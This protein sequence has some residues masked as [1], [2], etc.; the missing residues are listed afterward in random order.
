[1]FIQGGG[2]RCNSPICVCYRSVA[3][4]RFGF[5]LP[6]AIFSP[7]LAL[8]SHPPPSSNPNFCDVQVHKAEKLARERLKE[9]ETPSML[10]ALG[11]LTQDPECWERARE[12]S[13]RRYAH[14]KAGSGNEMMVVKCDAYDLV[15]PPANIPFIFVSCY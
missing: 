12:L 10:S 9:R 2:R 1:M 5:C 6:R 3:S 15:T 14:A 8:S 13:G 4:S 11:D 7:P